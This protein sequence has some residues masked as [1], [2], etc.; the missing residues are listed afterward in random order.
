MMKKAD[1]KQMLLDAASEA[2]RVKTALMKKSAE[3]MI[4]MA[5]GL[6][7][8]LRRRGTIYLAGN[9][10]S[11]ADC[12]HFATELVVRLSGKFERPSL[13]AVSLTSDSVLLTAA[14]NDYGFERVFVRQVESLVRQRDLLVVISTS[15]NSENL[16]L[17]ARA[18]KRKK[19]QVYALLGGDGGKLKKCANQAIVVPS[20]SVQRIQEEHIFIIHNMVRLVEQELFR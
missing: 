11:A 16:V 20:D 18:A 12:Q 17:A 2:G 13:P 9:G 1:K 4:D 5:A 10:G 19:V 15:G 6:A 7:A 14:G 3:A 8:I